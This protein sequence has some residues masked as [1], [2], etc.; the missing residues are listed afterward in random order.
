MNF[1]LWKSQIIAVQPLVANAIQ[2][3]LDL[4]LATNFVAVADIKSKQ[5][6]QQNQFGKRVDLN[7][8][9]RSS[10][11][12]EKSLQKYLL[13]ND[14]QRFQILKSCPEFDCDR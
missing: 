8:A 5:K 1:T 13:V 14:R 9:V 10:V 6:R 11:K 12:L 2:N 7:G 3:Q 4:I